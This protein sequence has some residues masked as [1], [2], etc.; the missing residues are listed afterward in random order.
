[1]NYSV[2]VKRGQL[3]RIIA[4]SVAEA[5]LVEIYREVVKAGG[6]PMVRM[7]ADE[8]S[9]ILFKGG[10]DEQLDYLNPITKYEIET[11]DCSI[12]VWAEANTKALTN[13]DPKRIARNSAAREADRGYLHA[14]GGGR[15]T[16]MVG[17]AVSLP[18]QRA[19]CGHVA[20]G[21]RGFRV[22]GGAAE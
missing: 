16:E 13:C 8:L 2:G 1:M 5:L 17:D 10:S 14:P 12:G 15:E 4:P 6:H 18:G 21:I 9:E 19:G 7:T 11:I 20:G 22:W 3:V